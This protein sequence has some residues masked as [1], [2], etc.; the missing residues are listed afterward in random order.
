LLVG[1][2]ITPDAADPKEVIAVFIPGPV[3]WN[4]LH[5]I[6]SR[7]LIGG[8]F[9]DGIRW[10]F[11]LNGRR[12]RAANGRL[13]VGLMHRAARQYLHA[14]LLG[15]VG[16]RLRRLGVDWLRW[17]RWFLGIDGIA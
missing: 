11:G 14:L 1:R 16:I 3:A 6:S 7:L 2:Y 12:S 4:P 10:L 5:I 8:E 17:R 13:T 9:L 15:L